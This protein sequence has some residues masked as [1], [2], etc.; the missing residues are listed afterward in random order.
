MKDL[1]IRGRLERSRS[2]RL[3]V[4]GGGGVDVIDEVEQTLP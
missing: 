3:L 2:A 4:M 1:E